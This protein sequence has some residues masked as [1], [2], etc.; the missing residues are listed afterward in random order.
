MF[1]ALNHQA[2]SSDSTSLMTQYRV[3]VVLSILQLCVEQS[4]LCMLRFVRSCYWLG[5]Q[6][7][8]EMSYLRVDYESY[9]V[10]PSKTSLECSWACF[11][12]P[13]FEHQVLS[14]HHSMN[15]IKSCQDSGY[16]RPWSFKV[17]SVES[18]SYSFRKEARSQITG[19]ELKKDFH[20]PNHLMASFIAIT[21]L[22]S[23]RH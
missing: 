9:L 17:L 19:M 7:C 23:R 14:C 20:Y 5:Y 4:D 8:T 22:L 11:H 2:F 21:S 12:C 6:T 13:L 10:P 18:Y 1:R 16:Q 3:K 15:S